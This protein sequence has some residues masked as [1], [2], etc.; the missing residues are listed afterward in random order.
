M[1]QTNARVSPPVENHVHL[2]EKE[3]MAPAFIPLVFPMPLIN[4][5]PNGSTQIYGNL[6][7]RNIMKNSQ[8][9]HMIQ[10]VVQPSDVAS[11]FPR[12]DLI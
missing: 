3:F 12:R 8:R 2:V 1:K 10:F 4:E 6:K 5:E 7:I 9:L 11:P